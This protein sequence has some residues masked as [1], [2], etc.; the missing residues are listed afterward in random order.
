MMPWDFAALYGLAVLDT[1]LMGYDD[2]AG[3]NAL[4]RKNRYYAAA[5]ARGIVIGH[6]F[7]AAGAVATLLAEGPPYPQ[8]HAACRTMLV[9]YAPYAA[10]VVA[11]LAA[12]VAPLV[13]VRSMLASIVLGPMMF[14]RPALMLLGGLAGMWM[15]RTPAVRAA[16]A[17]DV[18]LMVA[19]R[20]LLAL[21]RPAH[22]ARAEVKTAG[23]HAL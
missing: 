12:R 19:Y 1:A 16:I 6:V 20:P 18:L 23:D 9:V 8:L 7:I 3:R 11:A 21:F 17:F 13:D 4:I 14:V 22:R 15:A 2:A 10:L 5:M